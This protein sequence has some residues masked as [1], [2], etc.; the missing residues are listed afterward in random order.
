MFL[1]IEKK[2][3]DGGTLPRKVL[4]LSCDLCKIEFTVL[5]SKKKQLQRHHFC[6]QSCA[7]KGRFAPTHKDKNCVE[8][9]KSYT[10]QNGMQKRCDICKLDIAAKNRRNRFRID[11]KQYREMLRAQN[12][13]CA[14]CE[15]GFE[16]LSKNP[17]IDHC[18]DRGI[19]RG[20]L[21]PSCNWRLSSLDDHVW[22]KAAHSYI[23]GS[24]LNGDS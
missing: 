15:I 16:T 18:H 7:A 19:V 3:P 17:S 20:L 8:C 6:S 9:E 21:C 4:R 2:I 13:K 10:P 14:I 11:N 24:L 22:Y 23:T 1:L 5:H 12:Y